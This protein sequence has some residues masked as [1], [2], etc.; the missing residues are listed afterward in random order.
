MIAAGRAEV[1]RTRDSAL[2]DISPELVGSTARNALLY[3]K[4]MVASPELGEVCSNSTCQRVDKAYLS[5][6]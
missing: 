4:G 2:T 6:N 5:L 1:A 3:D